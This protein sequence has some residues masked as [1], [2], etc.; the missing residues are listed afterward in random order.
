MD[1]F[2]W[3]PRF[4]ESC[5]LSDLNTRGLE[6]MTHAPLQRGRQ[7]RCEEADESTHAAER[8][9]DFNRAGHPCRHPL[10]LGEGLAVAGSAP[11][12]FTVVLETA[13]L[14][15]T[16]LSAYSRERGLFPEQ[17]ERWRRPPRMPIKS[18]CS[19]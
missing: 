9:S 10:Q 12:K 7:S 3:T 8:G 11:D 17:V 14:N 1:W 15:A 18:Q 19:P 4:Q 5:H 13:G 6:D 16:E 2:F